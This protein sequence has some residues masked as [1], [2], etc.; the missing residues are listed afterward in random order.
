MRKILQLNA[1][2]SKC[3]GRFWAGNDLFV[4]KIS[5]LR[6]YLVIQLFKNYA[7]IINPII[8]SYLFGINPNIKADD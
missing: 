1:G 8:V 5:V 3:F 4:T 2:L 6:G 7:N